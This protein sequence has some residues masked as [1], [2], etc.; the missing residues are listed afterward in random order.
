MIEQTNQLYRNYNGSVASFGNLIIP[1]DI[2]WNSISIALSGGADSALLSFLLCD[3]IVKTNPVMTV[4]IISNI[5]CWKTRPWQSTVRNQVIKYLRNKFPSLNLVL[6]KNFVPPELEHGTMGK[7]ITDEYG[8]TVSGDTLELRAFAEYINFQHNCDAYYNAVTKNPPIYIEGSLSS[9][10]IDPSDNNLRLMVMKHMN[11]VA[12]HPF[13]FLDKSWIMRQYK[14]L[15]INDL[16][17]IT[18]SCEGEFGDI[19]YTSYT[20]GQHVPLCNTCFWCNERK[21]AIEQS[22]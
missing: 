12:C 2:K 22:K 17:D 14:E 19:D 20:V 6:H 13:R 21:W 7:T 11:T 10:D 15:G 18:R 5:R 8:K 16:L 9:R 4:H 1:F 3:K